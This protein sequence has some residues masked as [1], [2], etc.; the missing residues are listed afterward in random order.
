MYED[1]AVFRTDRPSNGAKQG[2]VCPFFFSGLLRCA[3]GRMA[4][5]FVGRVFILAKSL[6]AIV[7]CHL[8]LDTI[9]KVHMHRPSIRLGR[10][11]ALD[12][13]RRY[14]PRRKD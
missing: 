13:S 12:G 3:R 1:G 11:P 10:R 6:D 5:G 9:R 7:S 4:F 8:A 14:R 2:C